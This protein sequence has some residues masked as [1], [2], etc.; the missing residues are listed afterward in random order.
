VS[1]T[2]HY[3]GN[4]SYKAGMTNLW[5]MCPKWHAGRF[6]WPEEFIAIP[7]IYSFVQPAS[8]YFE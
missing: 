1:S 4:T 7:F 3:H 5:H 6:Y 2:T 8:L